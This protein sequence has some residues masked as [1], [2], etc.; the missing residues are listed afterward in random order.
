L[1]TLVHRLVRR[2]GLD[3][4][5]DVESAAPH[6]LN[7]A[8]AVDISESETLCLNAANAYRALCSMSDVRDL[9]HSGAALHEVPF[10]MTT[11]GGIV[12]G[13][14]DC[15]VESRDLLT[16]LE[17]KTGH[18]RPEHAAQVELYGKAVQAMHPGRPVQ[19]RVIY[20]GEAVILDL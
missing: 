14:I 1:G 10:T 11:E 6:L 8:E 4:E 19:T 13:T 3:P 7:A 17:F 5:A 20:L 16:V 15:L 9:Y 12:R 2:F 18:A